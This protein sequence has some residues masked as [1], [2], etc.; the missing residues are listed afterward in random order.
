MFVVTE[1]RLIN[2]YHKNFTNVS[3]YISTVRETEPNNLSLS[4]LTLRWT[5]NICFLDFTDW[6]SQILMILQKTY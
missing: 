4:S 5:W 3:F 2:E 6:I 1:K